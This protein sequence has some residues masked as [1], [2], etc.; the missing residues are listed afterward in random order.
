MSKAQVVN[1][2]K[3]FI[4]LENNPEVLSHLCRNLGLAPGLTFHDVLSTSPD[5]LSWIPRPIHAL[6]LLVDKPI[7]NA[8]RS[9]VIPKI[10]EYQDSG[11]DEPVFWIKQTIGHACGLMALLH[12]V[13]NLD[14]GRYLMP[15]STLGNLLKCAIELEPTERAQLLY[16]SEF[17]EEAHMDAASKGSS[18]PPSPHD[19]NHHHFIGFVQKDGQVWELNGGMNGPLCRGMLDGEDLLSERGLALTVQD[20]LDAAVKGGYGEISIVAIAGIGVSGSL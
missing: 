5:L 12:C 8:A 11:P 10:P 13:F 15:E 4:P 3:T 14:G 7:Y 6:I 20:F 1:G 16:D 18:T 9:A 17:L 2:I 19:E